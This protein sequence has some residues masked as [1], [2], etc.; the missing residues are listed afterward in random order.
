METIKKEKNPAAIALGKLG[1]NAHAKKMTKEERS[2]SARHAIQ[3]RWKKIKE[4]Q[5]PSP[6]A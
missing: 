1:G 6:E 2:A 4:Q 3:T 5:V